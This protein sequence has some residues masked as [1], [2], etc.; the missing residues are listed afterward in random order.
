MCVQNIFF[1]C[2][3]KSTFSI[4]SIPLFSSQDDGQT[5]HSQHSSSDA[6]DSDPEDFSFLDDDV[7]SVR[8]HRA[9]SY[10]QP[11]G[12]RRAGF[13]RKQI[14][15]SNRHF[16]T[17]ATTHPATKSKS[18]LTLSSTAVIACLL[19]MSDTHDNSVCKSWGS[20][21]VRRSVNVPIGMAEIH[22]VPYVEP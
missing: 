9:F 8:T 5:R 7:G 10:V 15:P 21:T 18:S 17:L 22:I 1:F 12:F 14:L 11:S 2:E 16:S 20:G 6:E 19:G 4:F 13:L 3:A